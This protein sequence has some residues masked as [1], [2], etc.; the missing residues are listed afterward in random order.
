MNLMSINPAD[1]PTRFVTESTATEEPATTDDEE[2]KMPRL[3]QMEHRFDRTVSRLVTR[4]RRGVVWLTKS[5]YRAHYR[6]EWLCPWPRV[7]I[8]AVRCVRIILKTL[9]S[10]T[11]SLPST[12]R[13]QIRFF[14]NS[15]T[16]RVTLT[17][18]QLLHY[19]RCVDL[20]SLLRRLE[21]NLR[22]NAYISLTECNLVYDVSF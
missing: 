3:K 19:N 11:P 17:C 5:R 2:E 14:G 6:R 13:R 18:Y 9:T 12:L 4:F 16:V 15:N 10:L 7:P 20:L 8:S 1:Y 22:F 21:P